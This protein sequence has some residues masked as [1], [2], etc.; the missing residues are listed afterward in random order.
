MA[1][2]G[3][4][5]PVAPLNG[6]AAERHAPGNQALQPK[7]EPLGAAQL[8]AANMETA[9]AAALPQSGQVAW[10]CCGLQSFSK[11]LSHGLQ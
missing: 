2:Q 4:E 7:P 11:V 1:Q 3:A 9:F 8:L 5:L 10:S 6:L